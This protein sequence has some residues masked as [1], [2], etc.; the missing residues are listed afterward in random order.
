[1]FKK[2]VTHLPYSPGLLNQVGFYTKRLK[3]E[4][5][6]RRV[7]LIFAVL[8]LLLNLNLSIFSPE[9]SV[10]ASPG[11]DVVTGGIYGS[12][13]TQMQDRT[14][15][16]MRSSAYTAAIF[17][18]YGITEADIRGTSVS[19]LNTADQ[20]L[21]SVGRQAFG[22]GA[23][24]C[25]THNG[26]SFCERSM[27]AA[28]RYR[29]L[30]VK[31]LTGVR[32]SRIGSS[33]PWFAV[34]ESCGNVV[35]RVG[36]DESITVDKTL[37]PNQGQT[38]EAGDIVDFRIKIKANNENGAL[39]PRVSDTLPEHTEYVD[40]SPKD[41]FSKAN[42]SGR[43]VE[44]VG[45]DS[46]YG[47][48]P[49]EERVITINARVLA[50]APHGAKLCNSVSASSLSD[51]AISNTK[52]C[53]TVNEPQ[54]EPACTSLRML[55]SGGTNKVRTFEAKAN[56]DGAT[57]S[58]YVFTFGDGNSET[59]NS[60]SNT[61]T[62]NHTYEP[63]SYTAKVLVKT[64]LGDVGNSGTCLVKLT[65]DPPTPSPA[66]TCDYIKL[67]SGSGFEKERQFEASATPQN[68]ASVSNFRID[69]GDGEED[70]IASNSSN[71][72]TASHAYKVAGEYVARVYV[73]SSLGEITN[74][75]SCK[76]SVQV[77]EEPEVCPYDPELL[78][79]DEDCVE[80]EVCPHNPELAPDDPEC[81]IPNI[82]KLKQVE[83]VTQGIEDAHGTVAN[84]GDTL[85]FTLLTENDGS[86]TE[87]DFV[88]RDDLADVL[89]YAELIDYD[90]GVVSDDGLSVTW[91][92]INIA[93]GEVVEKTITVKVLTPIPDTPVS[94]SDP[95]AFD[96]R[97]ENA[98]GNNVSVDLP[99]SVPKLI[100]GV[101]TTLPN[102]GPGM[103]AFVSTLFIGMV[104]YFYF[105]NR[106]I[107]KE[108][109][110]IRNEF[111]GG[112][113]NG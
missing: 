60:S 73:D 53:V 95:L 62:I 5:F 37:S 57:I 39:Y 84:A 14:I 94:A 49:N 64:S 68:G 89:Q 7:G 77:D 91:P 8:A 32:D 65:V 101:V 41:L 72:V 30:S 96:L 54:P 88:I 100:E 13:A 103:N 10:L 2:L 35:V 112:V 110:M 29:S 113:L 102:T 56:P 50:T 81:G 36:K 23:E 108:L 109:G 104:T 55:G 17:D 63:G 44:L 90:G 4:E 59:V 25:K 9:A 79:D 19:Y 47:L 85:R 46:L 98:Y 15:A 18:Y 34:L 70:T 67:L 20:S 24:S 69:Y 31:A 83:N 12:N 111:S 86:A 40:H 27:Y 22:R 33:D 48:G 107:A 1:M 78:R 106:L 45:T 3:Q 6:S 28:Y 61:A 97:M 80:P 26:Y 93:A 51:S 87:K 82:F 75:T 66:V 42:V 16:A 58:A 76:L 71:K 92:K 99:E 74:N 11:N 38:V 43:T 105:R 21:R 52:P